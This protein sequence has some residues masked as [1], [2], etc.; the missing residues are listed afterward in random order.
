MSGQRTPSGDVLRRLHEVLFA[1]SSAELVVPA[2]VKVL[3]WKKDKGNGVV[4][5]GAG[6]LGGDSIQV[7]GSVPGGAEVEYAYRAGYDSRGRVP[8]THLVDERAMASRS[9][10]GSRAPPRGAESGTALSAFQRF[11]PGYTDMGSAD[12]YPST[13]WM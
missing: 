8:V 1:P 11:R 5:H 12:R 4:I 6:G 7:G 2:E 3:A 10:D 9:T 13:S